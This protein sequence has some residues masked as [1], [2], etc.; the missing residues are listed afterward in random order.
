MTLTHLPSFSFLERVEQID[1]VFAIHGSP[2][3]KQNGFDNV[4]VMV[5]K[6]IDYYDISEPGTHVSILEYSDKPVVVFRLDKTYEAE[7]LKTLVDKMKPSAGSGAVTGDAI[8]KAG[9]ELFGVE[10]GGRPAANKVLVIV[11]DSSSTSAQPPREAIKPLKQA[12]VITYVVSIRGR[13]TPEDAKEITEPENIITPE[14]TQSIPD[15]ATT[16]VRKINKKIEEKRK[17][18]HLSIDR[19]FSTVDVCGVLDL[20]RTINTSV[21]LQNFPADKT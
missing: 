15:K 11:T 9:K 19:H 20:E 16:I 5:K 6:I 3:L 7:E 10:N 1:L 13:P 2:A 21:S 18:I 4:K 8:E 17:S 14:D 12:G